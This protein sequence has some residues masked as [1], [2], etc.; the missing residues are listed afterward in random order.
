MQHVNCLGE[1]YSVH[2]T[3][4]VA[5]E[6]VNDLQNAGPHKSFQRLCV[7]CL[8]A[9]LGIPERTANAPPNIFGEYS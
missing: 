5:V 1:P 3:K 2:G 6:V 4:G 8:Q 9:Q 7:R